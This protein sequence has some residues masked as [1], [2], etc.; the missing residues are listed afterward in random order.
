MY[1]HHAK[2][3][4][5]SDRRGGKMNQPRPA[6]DPHH[7]HVMVAWGS[8]PRFT[9]CTQT[10]CLYA[11]MD[12]KPVWGKKERAREYDQTEMFPEAM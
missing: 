4:G 10:G 1:G 6:V 5:V 12:G 7:T 2:R 11:E 3:R 9:K 8:D